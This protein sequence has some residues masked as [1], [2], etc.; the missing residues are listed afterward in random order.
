MLQLG[1]LFIL[2]LS[3]NCQNHT[4]YRQKKTNYNFLSPELRQFMA[5]PN[6]T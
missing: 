5:S 3:I 1:L 2:A 4:I 6:N